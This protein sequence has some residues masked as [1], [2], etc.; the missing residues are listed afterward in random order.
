MSTFSSSETQD[1]LRPLGE[2]NQW[3][4][5]IE[6]RS[7]LGNEQWVAQL[8]LTMDRFYDI[9]PEGVD[10]ANRL[11][12]RSEES[13]VGF[14]SK[15]ANIYLG[16]FQ[17]HWSDLNDGAVLISDHAPSYDQLRIQF[18]TKKLAV[19]SSLGELDQLGPNGSFY[20][21]DRFVE[22]GIRRFLSLHRLDFRPTD[23]LQI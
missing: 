13:H 7:A 19:T 2:P 1:V 15:Y 20:E 6:L 3:H 18:G 11:Y 10:I 8:G 23:K 5:R 14:R 16:R 12:V 22:G 17:Q 4:P 9:D 21:R